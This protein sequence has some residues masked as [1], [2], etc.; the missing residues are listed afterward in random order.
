MPRVRHRSAPGRPWR[1]VASRGV[2]C[3]GPV[4]V[5]ES[6]L[7]ALPA[8]VARAQE[9]AAAEQALREA[10]ADHTRLATGLPDDLPED[11]AAE[12]VRLEALSQRHASL[13]GEVAEVEARI[14]DATA[15]GT[16]GEALARQ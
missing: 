16:I 14:S 15:S 13:A 4:G 5:A 7:D 6:E 3:G 10:Q 8:R 12:V 1:G 11:L 2:R 9:R